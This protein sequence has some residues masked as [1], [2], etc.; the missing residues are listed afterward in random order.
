MKEN[1]RNCSQVYFSNE[2]HK[3]NFQKCVQKFANRTKEYTSTYYLATYPDIFKCFELEQQET[4]PFD[5]YF[6]CLDNISLQE[7]RS[8]GSTAPLTGQTTALVNLALNLWNGKEF[9][10]ASG[11]Y[12]WDSELYSF[13]L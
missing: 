10:L 7:H 1:P 11:L 12:I 9:D 3:H 5:W 8:T 4:G 2:A 13:A 6:D